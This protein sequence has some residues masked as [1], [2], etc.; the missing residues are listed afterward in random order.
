VT[1]RQSFTEA[2]PPRCS[3]GDGGGDGD[4]GEG[5]ARHRAGAD[6]VH[7]PACQ[8][9]GGEGSDSLRDE[10]Q[11]GAEWGRAADLLQVQGQQHHR[12]EQGDPAE[13]EQG[14]RGGHRAVPD[15]VLEEIVDTIFLPLVR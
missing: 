7:V 5:R 3:R 13:E 6:A 1:P 2:S 14:G 10:Q 4:E 15:D 12:S 11:S 9:A 8:A